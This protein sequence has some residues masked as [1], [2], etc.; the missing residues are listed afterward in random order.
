MVVFNCIIEKF[1]KKGEKTGWTY[2]L[3][4][5]RVADKINKNVRKSYRVKGFINQYPISGVS[6]IPMGE[7]DFILPLNAS[8]RKGVQK[9]T[10][11]KVKVQ[12]AVDTAEKKLS[13]ELILCLQD[14]PVAMNVFNVLPKSHQ[15]YYSNW[16]ESA[17]TSETRAK[18]ITKIIIGLSTGLSFGET[19]KLDI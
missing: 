1:E 16:V 13:E 7:G 3:I 8:M 6:L 19:M 11:D 12:L 2:L 17:K 18:R 5:A 14:E 9:K 4:P 10:G 15:R